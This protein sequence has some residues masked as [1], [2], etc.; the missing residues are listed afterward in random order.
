[1]TRLAIDTGAAA[2]KRSHPF[3]VCRAFLLLAKPGIVLAVVLSGYAGMVLAG[4]RLPDPLPAF[5]GSTSLF[6]TALGAAL[7]N[8][9]GDRHR[10]RSM[11]RLAQRS[12]ALQLLG[13]PAV[14]AAAAAASSAGLLL[15]WQ[16]LDPQVTLLLLLAV[17]SYAVLYTRFLKPASHWAALLGGVPGALPV[18]VGSAAVSPDFSPAAFWLF[19]VLLIWQPPH[20]WLLALAHLSDYRSAKLPVLPLVT[21]RAVTRRAILAG[22]TALIPTSLGLCWFG[23]CSLGYGAGAVLLGAWFLAAARKRLPDGDTRPAFA[24]SVLY[25]LCLLTLIIV[26]RAFP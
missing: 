14:A 13:V 5:Y 1:M 23:P 21:S 19:L 22:I 7:F 18:F 20:F 26:D 25:L 8:S 16:T 11:Q 12:A 9:L 2:K 15:S 6:L 3:Q 4:D 24:V 17:A 10:D